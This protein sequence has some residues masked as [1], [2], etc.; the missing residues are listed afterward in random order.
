VKKPGSENVPEECDEKSFKVRVV[1][2][3][4]AKGM[5]V[6]FLNIYVLFQRVRPEA[7]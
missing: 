2:D 5:P 3:L 7:R 6:I 1:N 4:K